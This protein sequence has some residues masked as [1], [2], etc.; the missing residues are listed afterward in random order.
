M[1]M[2]IFKNYNLYLNNGDQFE[3]ENMVEFERYVNLE[4][5]YFDGKDELDLQP[6]TVENLENVIEIIN[7]K[8]KNG[9][10]FFL[11]SKE[12]DAQSKL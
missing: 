9:I 11:I 4:L 5:K 8:N 3:I 10:S 7:K 12:H 1:K 2:E 6:D